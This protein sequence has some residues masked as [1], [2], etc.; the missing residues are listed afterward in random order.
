[1]PKTITRWFSD[2]SGSMVESAITM[3]ILILL[4][5]AFVNLALAGYASATAQNAANYGARVGAMAFSNAA[6]RALD[7]ARQAAS[8]GIGS[9]DIAVSAS[10][11]PGSTVYVTVGWQVPNFFAGLMPLFGQSAG[12]LKGSASASYRKEGW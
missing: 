1:M 5:L 8:G 9:Y 4:S 6:G 7:N 12:D 3:P 11:T 10:D 2:R